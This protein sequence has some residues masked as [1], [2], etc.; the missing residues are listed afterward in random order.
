MSHRARHASLQVLIPLLLGIPVA[1]AAQ[2]VVGRVLEQG[3]LEPL[4]A[5]FVVLQDQDG[6]RRGGVLTGPDGRFVLRAA[7]PGTYRLIT[8]MIGYAGVTSDDVELVRGETVER[9]IQVPVRAIALDGIQVSAGARCRARPGSGPETARLWGEAR[10]ALEVTSWSGSN[11]SVQFRGA[12]FD[13]VL[14]PGSLR[15]LQHSEHAW[16]G[17]SDRSPFLSIPAHELAANGYVQAAD[18]G[19]IV[20]YAPDAAVLL[21]DEFLDA[22]C[23]AV[24]APPALEPELIGLSFEPLRSAGAAGIR[25]V[26][27]LDRASAELRRLEFQYTSVPGL[28]ARTWDAAQ[29]RVEFERLSTG[30]WIVRRWWIRMPAVEVGTREHRDAP[31]N[32]VRLTAVHETGAEVRAVRGPDGRL[33]SESAGATLYGVV[34]EDATGLPLAGALVEVVASGRTAT[35][36]KDGAFRLTGLPAGLFAVEV[37]HP[38]LRLV[39]L[40]PD[41]RT[42]DLAAGQAARLAVDVAASPARAHA[43]CR[44]HGWETRR[45][46]PQPVLLLGLVTDDG[47]AP[48][49]EAMVHIAGTA[50]PGGDAERLRVLTDGEGVYSICMD[51]LDG[52]ARLWATPADAVVQGGAPDQVSTV[53]LGEAGFVRADL[54]LATQPVARHA[55]GAAD[56]QNALLGSVLDDE[57]QQGIGGAQVSLVDADGAVVR[58]TATDA[59]G[60][61]RIPNPGQG[62]AYQVR[63]EHVA[64]ATAEGTV[65]FGRSDQLRLQ[66]MLSTR[67]IALEPIVVTERRHGALARSGFY[68][69]RARGTGVFVE[70]DDARRLRTSSVTDLLSGQPAIRTITAGPRGTETDI[71]IAGTE[72]FDTEG[73]RDCQP[74]VYLDGSLMRQAGR[75]KPHDH[76]L[77][78]IVVPGSVAGIEVFRR[79]S[80]TPVRYRGAGAACGVVL[81]WTR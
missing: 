20:Y 21:S 11:A 5:A 4:S 28:P 32:S 37:S 1:T 59:T 56:W 65:R 9:T 70:V 33:L 14:D 73:M 34:T 40:E 30:V 72:Q 69:R 47:G 77:S 8:E 62:D 22:H 52:P 15:V 6:Q 26:L 13:R 10:K 50:A 42:V 57:T 3:T 61:F 67:A 63:V 48:A 43:V 31:T 76:V 25:G 41:V 46:A 64:Y 23:F 12:R 49:R 27:W 71:R 24:A 51:P 36:G 2:T 35:T 74:A 78:D 45:S 79:A 7:S 54:T 29:G 18:D 75:P 66:V 19:E 16:R 58:S 60:R 53:A 38:D 80:E 17:W 44:A 68:D 39:G 81:I 55:A